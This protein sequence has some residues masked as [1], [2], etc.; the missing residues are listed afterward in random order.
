M[1]SRAFVYVRSSRF[2]GK[3]L[4]RLRPFGE[5]AVRF[6]VPAAIDTR[7]A[8]LE[9]LRA[10]PGV[11]DAVLCEEIGCV[12]FNIGADRSLVEAALA[13]P[14]T[15]VSV[16]TTSHAVR[17]VYDGEDV[18]AVA[19]AAGLSHEEVIRRHAAGEYRVAMLGFL[20][21]F[22]YLRGLHASLR[23]PR[24][25]PRPRVP[26]NAVAIAAD[27]T[28][29]YPIASA[30]GW[31]LLGRAID[32][33]AFELGDRVRF[34]AVAS[35]D[36]PSP[37]A[38]ALPEPVG[39]H[40]VVTRIAGLALFVH[41]GRGGQMHRGEPP[42]GPL[43]RSA[44][45]ATNAAAGNTLDC[46]I[47]LTGQLEVEA[48][49]GAVTIAAHTHATQLNEGERFTLASGSNR[50]VYLAIAGGFAAAATLLSAGRGRPLRRG[51]TLA[52]QP[53][54]SPPLFNALTV[55]FLTS[56]APHPSSNASAPLVQE[57]AA[58]ALQSAGHEDAAG[59]K[60]VAGPHGWRPAGRDEGSARSK[61]SSS[62]TVVVR[63]LRGPDADDAILRVICSAEFTISSSSD[64]TGTRLV[65][66]EPRA[67]AANRT[68]APMVEGAIELTPSGLALGPE[69][70]AEAANRASAPMVEGAIELTPS[71]L[72]LARVGA[73][74]RASAPMV[75]GAIE[76]TP[77]GL[78]VLGPD[79]PTTGGYP[80]VAVIAADSRDAFFARPLGARVRFS[81]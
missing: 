61:S 4:S 29:I 33:P 26:A 41:A 40:L 47:E 7:R 68:S 30:G 34:V 49:G 73:T 9:R 55:P 13:A 60:A 32:T 59:G 56:S 43:I 58:P 77:S 62:S 53:P 3:S 8:L 64:R 37:E 31:H 20:P 18:D 67:E 10:V 52:A 54:A 2:G 1:H 5:S 44:F 23:L 74:N 28:G 24:R 48:R 51:D 35:G 38:E 21:G 14:L 15:E 71:G 11:R 78:V 25:A 17:V 65:G 80:V 6:E 45:A 46:A 66:P 36:A 19:V 50:A 42:G 70:R 57:A 72:V 76:L 27:Y 39:A 75:E 22:A 16:A 69:P 63:I 12:M 81:V 79:H